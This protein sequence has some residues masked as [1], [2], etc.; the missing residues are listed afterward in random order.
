MLE[1]GPAGYGL[2][3]RGDHVAVYATFKPGELVPRSALRQILNPSQLN[4]L[5]TDPKAVGPIVPIP[6]KFT[7]AIVPSARVL[8]ILNPVAVE[9]SQFSESDI[10]V[11]LD[12]SP[13]TRRRLPT[14]SSRPTW[15]TSACCRRRTRTATRSRPAWESPTASSWGPRDDRVQ[16]RRRRD[17]AAAAGAIPRGRAGG[18][19][20][21]PVRD[22][23]R[24]APD[25]RARP[26]RRARAVAGGEGARRARP[27]R[28]RRAAGPRH[29]DRH[30]PRPHVERP[31]SRRDAGRHPRRRGHD[32]GHRGAARRRRTGDRVGHE[33]ALGR[34]RSN[35]EPRRTA[36]SDH[37]GLFLE[38]RLREDVPDHQPGLRDLGSHGTGHR[39]G[40]PGL[41]HGRRLHLLRDEP[42]SNIP[43]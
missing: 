43:T 25:P 29:R 15:S 22:G 7:A 27:R 10:P 1:G 31:A 14:P 12:L 38:R 5:L 21:G 23:G 11:T 40:G 30:G 20:L 36:R 24:G 28:V 16:R 32:A 26:R 13:R 39:R 19:G 35:G 4:K 33:P 41:R 18:G 8:N 37:L 3:Q 9:G 42:S 17:A 34:R 2:I 6:F